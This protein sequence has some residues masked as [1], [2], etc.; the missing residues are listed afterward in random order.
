MGC[1]ILQI[2]SRQ[3]L[4]EYEVRKK[5]IE[6]NA[7]REILDIKNKSE[8]KLVNLLILLVYYDQ[9]NIFVP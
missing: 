4:R 7:D 1:K 9:Q 5:E 3:Q 8:R 2:L 6:E